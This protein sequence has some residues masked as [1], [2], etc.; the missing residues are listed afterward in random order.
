MTEQIFQSTGQGNDG[1]DP[2]KMVFTFIVCT[3]L[4]SLV[5]WYLITTTKPVS[6]NASFMFS[7]TIALMWCPAAGAIVTRLWH[8]R[9][10]SGFELR[11]APVFWLGFGIIL[12]VLVGLCMFGSAWFLGIAS[13]DTGNAASLLVVSSVPAIITAILFSCFAAFGEE[14]G[15]RGLLVPELYRSMGF[16]GTALLSGTI[17]ALWH[18]PLIIFGT[19]H[20]IGSIW[21][22]LAI[23]IPSV[24]GSGVVMAWLRLASGSVWVTV[25]Y[26]G[27]WN[28][29][30]QRFYPDLTVKTQAGEMMLGEFGW[31]VLVVFIVL[32]IIFWLVRNRLPQKG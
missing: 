29:F 27:F 3:L 32:A 6:S 31:F 7:C 23:F 14:L 13:F 15:W 11:N 12:P 5:F 26:H 22:S 18:I 25:L 21:F 30:I 10:L 2:K 4:F 9:N 1:T 16:T 17:W 20:G 19:Y 28:Y 8:Q 24:I